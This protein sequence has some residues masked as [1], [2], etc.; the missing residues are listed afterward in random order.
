M[1]LTSVQ[2]LVFCIVMAIAIPLALVIWWRRAPRGS[3][4]A[5]PVFL[6]GV[7]MAQAAAVSAAVVT[8]GRFVVLLWTWSLVMRELPVDTAWPLFS[9]SL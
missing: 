4:W 7:L 2:F 1:P 6:V 9:G 8:Y 3:H 5:I